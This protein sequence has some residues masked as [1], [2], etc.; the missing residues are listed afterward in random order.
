MFCFH[1]FIIPTLS[2]C[3]SLERSGKVI[4][5]IF[6]LSYFSLFYDTKGKKAKNW[7]TLKRQW[8]INLIPLFFTSNFRII[9]KTN[10]NTGKMKIVKK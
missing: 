4:T 2:S 5:C 3:I 7:N 8:Q 9:N 10:A 1:L 6:K